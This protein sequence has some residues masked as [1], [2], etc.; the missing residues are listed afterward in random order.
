MQRFCRLMGLITIAAWLGPLA[1]QAT[2][3]P[4]KRA[5]SV[6][7]KYLERFTPPNAAGV[8]SKAAKAASF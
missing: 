4:D 8:V 5:R 6:S 7:T 3:A 1:V 2:A